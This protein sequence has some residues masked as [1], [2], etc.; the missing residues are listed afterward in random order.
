MN[1]APNIQGFD[2]SNRATTIVVNLKILYKTVKKL[3]SELVFKLLFLLLMPLLLI[4]VV[5]GFICVQLLLEHLLYKMRRTVKRYK[6][7][8]FSISTD[9]YKL[10]RLRA[11]GLAKDIKVLQQYRKVNL[12]TV[13]LRYR[14]FIRFGKRFSQL[15]LE[16]YKDLDNALKAFDSNAKDGQFFKHVSSDDLWTNRIKAYEYTL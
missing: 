3:A 15:Q 11:E 9:D 6:A 13:S 4:V 16:L 10:W 8:G 7:N 14:W 5:V 2:S 1:L 12:K